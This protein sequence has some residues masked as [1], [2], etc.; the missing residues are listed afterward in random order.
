MFLF[1][2]VFARIA[3]L[4][5]GDADISEKSCFG[6]CCECCMCVNGRCVCVCVRVCVCVNRRY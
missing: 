5:V 3:V 2:K 4:I 1:E 6:K